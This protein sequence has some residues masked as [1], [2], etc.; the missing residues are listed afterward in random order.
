MNRRDL[1]RTVMAIGGAGFSVGLGQPL[2]SLAQTSSGKG[3]GAARPAGGRQVFWPDGIRLPVSLSLMFESGA[4]ERFNPATPFNNFVPPSGIYDMPTISWYRYG[5]TEGIPRALD[6]FARLRIPVTSH[7]SGQAVEMYPDIARSITQAGHEAAAHGWDWSVES[8]M[9]DEQEKAFIQRN[10]DV[11][12]KVTGQRPI[13]FNAPGLRGS[14]N[15]LQNLYSLG[16]RYHIDDV[17]RDEPFVVQLDRSREIAVVPYAVYLNDIRAYEARYLADG[18][19]FDMMKR[20]FDRLYREAGSRRRMMA[21]TM[22]DRLVRP[23]HA[24]TME[25]LLRYMQ[26]K[27]GVSFLKK[28]DIADFILQAPNAIREPIGVVYPTI[29]GLYRG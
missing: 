13:G 22:H 28:V 12:Q 3:L 1:L 18:D 7:M 2:R 5:V 4:Q 29:P 23:E 21:I 11:I 15:I 20:S 9:N 26:R 25:E 14:R 19:F 17:S 8:T 27:A 10:V 16:F 6:L 24:E